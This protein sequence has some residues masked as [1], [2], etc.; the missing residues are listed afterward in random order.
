MRR[1]LTAAVAL[2]MVGVACNS[3]LLRPPA[4][5]SMD[6]GEA[7]IG[8]PVGRR[9]VRLP[10]A[11]L[12]FIPSKVVL[13]AG[14]DVKFEVRYTGEPH[15]VALGRLVDFAVG[16]VQRLGPQATLV[17]IEKLPQLRRLPS[18]FPFK[19]TDD[20]PRVNRSAAQRCFLVDERPPTSDAGG[21][22]AC[23]D[24]EQ[25]DF[26]GTETFFSSGFIPEGEGFRMSL[27]K[28]IKPG[29][30]RFMCLVHRSEMTGTI[31]V[32]PS[33]VPRPNVRQVK[34]AGRDEQRVVH[35]SL[36]QPAETAARSDEAGE[37]L[38]GAGPEGEV[39][40]FVSAFMPR[41]ATAKVGEPV[42]WKL[43]QSHTISFGSSRKAGEGILIQDRDGAVKINLDAWR[44]VGLKKETPAAAVS[45]PPRRRSIEVDG[46]TWSADGTLSSGV[47]RAIPPT[48]VSFTMRFA[49]AG[50]YRYVCLVHSSMRGTVEVS[51]G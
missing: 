23:P 18:V 4:I 10:S 48:K 22:Q 21:T 42:T 5:I 12:S 19:V 3:R 37:I 47:L 27:S 36:Q 49:K 11:Y 25:P 32:T 43:F 16:A 20:S 35:A 39:R 13:H 46:G 29:N 50:T 17:E 33:D 31:E 45:Y 38:A 34:V 9:V 40:A 44:A 30:Y 8:I 7:V 24:V 15:T 6:S 41:E 26:K 51:E 2:L 1:A 14:D 28:D